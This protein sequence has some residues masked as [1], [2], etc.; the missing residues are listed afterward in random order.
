MPDCV[1]SLE[2]LTYSQLMERYRFHRESIQYIDHLL[3]GRIQPTTAR[4]NSLTSLGKSVDYK[5]NVC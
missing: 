5:V 4:S 1:N 2:V 3:A